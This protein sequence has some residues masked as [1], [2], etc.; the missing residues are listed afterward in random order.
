MADLQKLATMLQEL[1]DQMAACMK[2]GMCQGVC[3]VFA[4]TMAEADVT[5][6]K[7]ALLENLAHELVV[8]AEGVKDKLNKCLLCGSCAA[9]CPSGVR[10]MDIFL[11]ARCIVNGYLGLSPAKKAIL[12]GMLTR[13]KLF[14]ALLDTAGKFQGL[15]TSKADEIV[16][17]S[18]S[19]L[20]SPIIGE[21]HFKPLAKEPLHAAVPSLDTAVGA[22]GLKIAFYPGCAVD[23]FFPQVGHAAFKIFRHH[24]V[25]VFMPEGQACCGLPSLASGDMESFLRLV[26]LNVKLFGQMPFDYLVTPCGSCTAA[27]KEVWPKF[28]AEMPSAIRHAAMTLADKAIDINAF[29][30]DKLGVEVPTEAPKGGTPLTYHDPCHLDKSLH[31]T[32]QPRALLRSNPNYEFREMSEHNRCCGCGGSFNLYHYDVSKKIGER[33]RENIVASGAKVVATGC[34]ACMLQISDMLSQA[35]DGIAVKHAIEIYAETLG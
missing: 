23:K 26:E 3:P 16:G 35:G 6:G 27:F 13:P 10:I 22:S 32:A 2:C 15:V 34:P 8:D 28:A 11:K 17:T 14:N 19:R 31:V 18:C 12:R 20:M 9:N 7:I 29:I 5:R 25:G 24:G 4:E 21:R 33:K 30:V 1:D